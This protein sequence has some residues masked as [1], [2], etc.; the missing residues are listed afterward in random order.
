MLRLDPPVI[1]LAEA[2]EESECGAVS[3][4][5][6]VHCGAAASEAVQQPG[7]NGRGVEKPADAN[8]ADAVRYR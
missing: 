3:T 4:L 6:T 5:R 7:A 1:E 8:G 2:R